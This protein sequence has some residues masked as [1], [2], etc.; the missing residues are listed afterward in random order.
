MYTPENMDAASLATNAFGQ[1]FNVTMTQLAASF[2]SLIN[3]GNYYEPHVVKQ[4]Q[5]ENGNVTENIDPVLVKKTI[6]EE[7]S[8]VIKDYM[9]GVVQE[10]TGSSAAVEGL[11]YRRKD[12]YGREAS[13][14]KREISGIIHWDMHLRRIRR[15]WFMWWLMSPMW[16]RRH[17]VPMRQSWRR[18]SCQKSSRIWGLP[19]R[20][21][22]QTLRRI[23]RITLQNP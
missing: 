10:G 2:C 14:W 13:P 15:L 23:N 1:N 20:Q 16:R 6:S 17:P 21:R 5:D 11:R 7:T 4:I 8:E 3:G 18:G 9:L 22:R 19:N 12:R